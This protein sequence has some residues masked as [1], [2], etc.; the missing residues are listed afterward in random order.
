VILV[1]VYAGCLGLQIFPA[2]ITFNQSPTYIPLGDRYMVCFLGSYF[3]MLDKNIGPW[4]MAGWI[5]NVVFDGVVTILTLFR[6]IRL[7]ESG[8]RR[9]LSELML[10][11]GLYYFTMV[12]TLNV[13]MVVTFATLP[14][15]LQLLLQRQ[16]QVLTVVMISH[17][18]LN[19][20]GR[21]L[22]EVKDAESRGTRSNTRGMHSEPLETAISLDIRVKRPERISETLVENLG[23]D[24]LD[25][26]MLDY[27]TVDDKT[28]S[29]G[30]QF[31][32][33]PR[34]LED[35]IVHIQ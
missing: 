33:K 21:D 5:G 2:I 15:A 17:M 3:A 32:D 31:T 7:R 11:D 13:A 27:W 29:D 34:D 26:S 30:E 25:T 24:V 28:E 23:T 9:T 16:T 10:R 14:C 22:H 35:S 18:F 6:A 20:K 12:L 1:T 19:L 8:V 4:R